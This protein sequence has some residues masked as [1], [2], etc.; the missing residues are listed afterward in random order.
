[1]QN[2][3]YASI[4]LAVATLIVTFLA[5]AFDSSIYGVNGNPVQW[6]SFMPSGPFRHNGVSLLLA[7]FLH[8]NLQHLGINLLLFLPVAL[9]IERKLSGK[10]LLA[11][12]L[13]IHVLTMVVL[14]LSAHTFSIGTA[15]FVGLSHIVTGLY[16]YWSLR[17]KKYSLMVFALAILLTGFWQDQ[18]P[19]TILAH[20]LGLVSGIMLFGAGQLRRVNRSERPH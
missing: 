7:P 12:F 2:R 17:Q 19:L 18:N 1:M 5:P 16:A 10:S 8:V 6:M 13:A 9:M 11:D 14:V 15:S 4:S 20:G 3:P